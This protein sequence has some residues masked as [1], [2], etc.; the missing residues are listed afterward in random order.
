MLDYLIP[1]GM[2]LAGIV[3]MM[4][5]FQSISKS[6]VSGDSI[7]AIR[8]P[9]SKRSHRPSQKY[10][11]DVLDLATEQLIA[12]E[13]ARNPS[14]M[15]TDSKTVVPQTLE[16]IR[17]RRQEKEENHHTHAHV[18]V[19]ERQ[20]QSAKGQG[21][22]VVESMKNVPKQQQKPPAESESATSIEDLDRKLSLFFKS[23]SSRKSKDVKLKE[24]TPIDSGINRGHVVVKGDFS[25][26]KSW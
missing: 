26:A 14:G 1:I 24:E 22:K 19:S 7:A 6:E 23:N 3:I 10:M 16:S 12:R 20:K 11:D 13:V 18:K 5:I 8:K 4:F 15:I 9:R 17:S 2:A 25:K 21:F